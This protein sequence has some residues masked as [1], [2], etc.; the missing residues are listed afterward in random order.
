M[1]L[2]FQALCQARIETQFN[3]INESTVG[4]VFL[5]TPHQGS[6][7]ATYGKILARVAETAA[8]KPKSRI[9]SALQANSDPF[10]RLTSD[11]RFQL[12]DYHVV[13]FYELRPTKPFSTLVRFTRNSDLSLELI[14]INYDVK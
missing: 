2:V 11:F 10:M 8:H 6:E 1:S 13:S 7:K 9:I 4:I 5:G 3:S 14:G 12:S